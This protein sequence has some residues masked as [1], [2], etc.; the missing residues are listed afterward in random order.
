MVERPGVKIFG[1]PLWKIF[2]G[3]KYR[4]GRYLFLILIPHL[5]SAVLEGASFAFILLAFSAMEGNPAHNLAALPFVKD[6]ISSYSGMQ[7][8][9][10]YILAAILLQAFRSLI[11]YVALYGTSLLAL[12]IQTETQRAVYQQ[13]FKFTYSFLS[14]YKI[15][16]LSEYIKNPSITIPVFFDFSNRFL[17]SSFM[18]IGLLF[19]LYFI[20]PVLTIL[21]V[22]IFTTFAFAQKKLIKK[23]TEYSIQLTSHLF[24]FS[25]QTIQSLYGIRPIYIFQK[26]N[27]VIN[28]I[29]NLLRLIAKSTNKVNLL[30]NSIPT[31][32]ETINVLLVGAV[33]ILGSWIFAQNGQAVL[34][35]LLTYIALTY[36]LATRLQICMSSVSSIGTYYGSILRVNEILDEKDKE[37][38][39]II[40]KK[41][42]SWSKN[43]KFDGVSLLYPGATEFALNNV[44][45]SIQKGTTVA[46]VGLSG[47]GKSSILDLILGLQKP[48]KGR[49]LIDSEN[50]SLFC[51]ESWLDQIGVVSQD[52]FLFNATIEENVRFGHPS[53]N[54]EN[55]R[56]ACDLA[57]ASD[58]IGTLPDR[59]KTTIGERGY[60]LSGGERQRIALARALLRNPTIFILDEATSNLDSYSERQIQK[61]LEQIKKDKT[62]II[63]AHRLSTI[64]HADQILV[65]EKGEI[66]ECGNHEELILQNGLYSKLWELQSEKTLV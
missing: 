17:V 38:I 61:S 22:V 60:K 65:L 25:H 57:G 32:N 4:N 20:S 12:K 5:I 59:F 29:E 55:I 48:I 66:V 34:S 13:I 14:K 23:V 41:I 24:E 53:A 46:F 45:F 16:D 39:P 8:F 44:T 47:A 11:T 50:L 64:T 28:K 9:Y 51:S 49:V 26:Q 56:F 27:Y 63:V 7:L 15:G 10:L 30:N 43:I 40:D 18:S 1:T 35:N 52:T 33:L 42:P 58:F 6:L 19:V 2:V 37:F 54:E 62:L 21:T 31:I 3:P 36:R